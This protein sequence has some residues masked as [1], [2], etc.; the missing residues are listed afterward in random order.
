MKLGIDI[1]EIRQFRHL[2]RFF[3][4]TELDYIAQKNNSLQTVAGLFAAKEAYFKALGTG[5]THNTL[6]TIEI[7]HN[8]RGAPFIRENVLLS[9][10]HTK[11]V[12]AAVCIVLD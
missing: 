12:A 4:Q 3:T 1:Q 2:K 7:L 9:I 8:E 6:K 11:Q 10:T 5:I